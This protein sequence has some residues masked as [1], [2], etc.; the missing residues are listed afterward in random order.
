MAV[1]NKHDLSLL[2][3]V[4]LVDDNYD[5]NAGAGQGK[6]YISV[7]TLMKP[8]KQIILGDR[9][10]KAGAQEEDVED[11]IS[12]A[13]GHTV[14]DGIEK[15]WLLGYRKNLLRL[16]YPE[17]VIDLVRI[18]PTDEDREAMPDMIPVFLEQRGFREINGYVIGGK[19]DAVCDGRVEDNKSTTAYSWTAGTRDEDYQLQG[20]LYNWI[21][22]ARP[23]PHIHQSYMRVNFIF[24][25]W[26]KFMAKANPEYPQLR[27]LHKDIPLLSIP[28]TEMFVRAKIHSIDKFKDAAE[29]AMPAC[30]DEELWRSK[31]Q[32][33]YYSDPEKAKDP[34]ARSTKNFDSLVEANQYLAEKVKGIVIT[35][36]G[37]VKRCPYCPAYEICEQRRLYFND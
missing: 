35:K 16:G 7:T 26:Q 8:V 36:P 29:S 13:L 1:S 25:D 5:H 23:M 28:D 30:T 17:H 2:L 4:W 19:Y 27:V 10:R 24:T 14:H 34:S 12:R 11:Y 9:A 6:P 20:S 15:A 32:Y 3:A 21:D 22:K 31:P 37:E 33:K 18:N